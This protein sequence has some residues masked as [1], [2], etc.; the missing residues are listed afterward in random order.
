MR[1]KTLEEL[2]AELGF[3][4]ARGRGGRDR[5]RLVRLEIVKD[6]RESSRFGLGQGNHLLITDNGRRRSLSFFDTDG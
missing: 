1:W 2:Q 4:L 5:G 3:F 6:R